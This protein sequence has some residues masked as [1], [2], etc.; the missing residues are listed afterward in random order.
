MSRTK[1]IG[2]Q[3]VQEIV[4]KCDVLQVM[5]VYMISTFSLTVQ[6]MGS[7]HDLLLFKKDVLGAPPI[8]PTCG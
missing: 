4:S 8:P 5:F 1:C 7:K 3:S 2:T 6:K